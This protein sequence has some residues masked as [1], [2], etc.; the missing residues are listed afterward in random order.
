VIGKPILVH[1]GILKVVAVAL[2][3]GTLVNLLID[4]P[5]TWRK[6]PSLTPTAWW[7]MGYLVVICTLIGYSIWYVVIRETDVSLAAMTILLQ[8]AVGVFIAA[9]TVAEPLHWGQLWGSAVIV[10]SLI[11]GLN[12]QRAGGAARKCR[13]DGS[14]AV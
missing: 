10:L 13:L 11:I 4:G 14:P 12:F 5:N 7:V 8:P 3:W 1:S 2:G 6:L 9:I